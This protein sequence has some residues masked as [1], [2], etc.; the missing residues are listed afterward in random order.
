MSMVSKTQKLLPLLKYP[1]GKDKEL[2][3]ILPNLP[4][5]A[6]NYYEPF[7]GGGAVYFAVTANKYFI[8]DKSFEL[9]E[10]YNM[11]KAQ[12][13][14]F[15]YALEQIEHNW[16]IISEV[17]FNH[18]EEI[19]NI[20]Y[21]Y[22]RGITEKQKLY[23]E[24]SA[25]ILHNADEFNG[26]LSTDF[27]VGIQ[28]FIN[29]LIRSF[30]NKIARMVEIECQKGDLS[31]SDFI[32]N[33]ECAFKSA[34]YMH[35]RY[36]Y[37]NADELKLSKA[38]LT[39]IYFYIREYCY[40]S[41]FR[42][43]ANGHFNVPY[44][45]ISYNKKSL[46]KKIEYFTSSELISHLKKTQIGCLDFETFLQEYKPTLNDFMFLDPPYDTEFSTYAKNAFDKQDQN[47]LAEY[48]KTKCDCYF[49]L[50]IKKSDYI[51]SLYK[52]GDCDKN[53]RTI[54]IRKFDKKYLVSFQNRNNKDAEHLVITNY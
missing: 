43:N 23:D 42:Y 19:S 30:K 51:L 12:N 4:S 3:H 10:L 16:Q 54:R 27:N 7:V 25:F 2:C 9:I 34:F 24:I 50:I 47:R 52:D 33:I 28:N 5:N 6:E 36:L 29:E 48:L 45:G 11:V 49:M 8:N 39:A 35:F 31:K 40:S 21:S 18:A 1:G 26:L 41:M 15:L 32:Q 44:G 20:Y 22:K 13:A 46:A 14:E 37:N 38:F 17:V 53:G